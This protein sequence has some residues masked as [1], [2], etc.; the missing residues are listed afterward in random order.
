MRICYFFLAVVFS[1]V[2]SIG[3]AVAADQGFLYGFGAGV[4]QE[5]YRGYSS[6][7]IPLPIL[8]YHGEKLSV[9]GPF[10]SYKLLEQDNITLS[11]KLA[12]RFAGF[13]ESD[14]S[15]FTGMAK[16]KDSLDGGIGIQ[17]RQDGWLLEADTMFDLLGNSNGLESKL[18][19][20]Y[21][22][23]AIV[24]II[25]PK[26]SISYSNGKLISYYYSVSPL[27]ATAERAVYKASGTFNY[28]AGVSLITPLFFRGI[29][30]LGIEHRWYGRSI[31]NSPL[32]DRDSRWSA[33]LSWSTLF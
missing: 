3:N 19:V 9:Y 17:L 2:A 33:T 26:F 10:I 18:E 6:R 21:S 14:S 23:P 4:N 12:P 31:S 32:T 24:M 15:F 5:I 22:Y 11:T 25:E 8:G 30:R 27:E 20:G 28:S 29:T 7:T 16:R 13:D 1:V